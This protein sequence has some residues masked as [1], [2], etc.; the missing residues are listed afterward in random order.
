MNRRQ[1]WKFDPVRASSECWRGSSRRKWK[2]GHGDSRR[3]QL[4]DTA[5]QYSHPHVKW[6]RGRG[7]CISSPHPHAINESSRRKSQFR[8]EPRTKGGSKRADAV[9]QLRLVSR[10]Q[11][12]TTST[13]HNSLLPSRIRHAGKM[14]LATTGDARTGGEVAIWSASAIT[15]TGRS[16]FRVA[17]EEMHARR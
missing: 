12:Q 2:S 4:E 5:I 6:H 8:H 15:A 11:P 9:R 13:S 3:G 1:E 16:R 10:V 7:G 17:Q 14:D